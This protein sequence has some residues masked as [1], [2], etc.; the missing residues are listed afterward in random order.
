M[1][2]QNWLVAYKSVQGIDQILKGMQR[3]TKFTAKLDE[4]SKDLVL[5]YTDLEN[6]FETFFEELIIFSEASFETLK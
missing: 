6:D 4:A 3:R 2:N 5:H 1:K